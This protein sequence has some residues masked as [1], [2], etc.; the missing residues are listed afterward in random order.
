M[1]GFES[2]FDS[3]LLSVFDSD[4]DSDFESEDADEDE[5]ALLLSP[6]DLSP[7]DFEL[8]LDSGDDFFA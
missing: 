5:V 6:D 4:F 8:E 7:D 2:L 1:E 3:V